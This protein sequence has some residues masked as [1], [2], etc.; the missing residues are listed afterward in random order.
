MTRV[1]INDQFWVSASRGVRTA[2]GM[3]IES[4]VADPA[5]GAAEIAGVVVVAI[6]AGAVTLMRG[7]PT[8]VAV[9]ARGEQ[10][11]PREEDRYPR[12]ALILHGVPPRPLR[13]CPPTRHCQR[14][15]RVRASLRHVPAV[16]FDQHQGS[17]GRERRC[18]PGTSS[19]APFPASSSTE[20]LIHEVPTDDPDA[21]AVERGGLVC[22]LHHRDSMAPISCPSA[23]L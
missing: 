1:K 14:K 7:R 23:A 8:A 19:I 11:H 6:N 15:W 21:H 3:W 17:Q 12:P 22:T 2:G 9:V 5:I 10:D 16:W 13:Q 20:N 4:V 18:R